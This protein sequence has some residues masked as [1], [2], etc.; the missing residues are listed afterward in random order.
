MSLFRP[1]SIFLRNFLIRQHPY[2]S[3]C[4]SCGEIKTPLG[5]RL[6]S[7][8]QPNFSIDAVVIPSSSGTA[9]RHL[10]KRLRYNAP[11]LRAIYYPADELPEDLQQAGGMKVLSAAA[12][13]RD[14]PFP[15]LP[16]QA[17][18][19]VHPGLAECFLVVSDGGI[20]D[21]PL[22]PLDFFTPNGIPLLFLESAV[23][24]SQSGEGASPDV[25]IERGI[26]GARPLPGIYAATRD[27]AEKFL[28]VFISGASGNGASPPDFSSYHTLLSRWTY[29]Q[30]LAVPAGEALLRA[31][32]KAERQRP[33]RKT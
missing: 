28:P 29:E 31:G 12:L 25:T 21:R 6:C 14:A 33:D 10:A 23:S 18:L 4:A 2:F 22:H 3:C 24:N 26:G 19:H 9:D 20:T 30:G 5:G 8:L 11:W 32:K 7:S 13:S 17:V 1:V 15:G 16:V 27:N